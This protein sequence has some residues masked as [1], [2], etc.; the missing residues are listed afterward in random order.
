M[1]ESKKQYEERF[2]PKPTLPKSTVKK[3]K[4][5]SS[6]MASNQNEDENN[7][8]DYYEFIVEYFNNYVTGKGAK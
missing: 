5:S 6:L 4:G 7:N 1:V 2:P 3:R 8:Y